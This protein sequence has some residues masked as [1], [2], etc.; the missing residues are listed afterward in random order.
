MNFAA[1]YLIKYSKHLSLMAVLSLSSTVVIGQTFEPIDTEFNIEDAVAIPPPPT[2]VTATTNSAE[3]GPAVTNVNEDTNSLPESRPVAVV[4]TKAEHSDSVGNFSTSQMSQMD[5]VG[6]LDVSQAVSAKQTISGFSGESD[7]NL[8]ARQLEMQ[9]QQLKRIEKVEAGLKKLVKKQS[10]S[11][12]I[13]GTILSAA[14]TADPVLAALGGIAGFLMGKAEDY[15][16]AEKKNYD[17]QQVI[18]RKSP[19]S[20]TDEELKL[21]AYAD[22]NL[23]PALLTSSQIKTY[24]NY[25]VE[26]KTRRKY[27]GENLVQPSATSHLGFIVANRNASYPGRYALASGP[28]NP[29]QMPEANYADI[30]Y[31]QSKSSADGATSNAGM[32]NA[33]LTT[34]NGN[35]QSL[36]AGHRRNLARYCFYSMR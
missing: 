3:L 27:G 34:R 24:A 33:S 15:K 12:S 2:V 10:F 4:E 25:V 20:Y 28:I 1:R 5:S 8:Q 11:K 17:I 13:M 35:T 32:T 23:D 7:E 6:L 18:I 19:S 26:A 16:Q 36:P 22:L 9:E 31:R 30:C 29:N 14:T 21:A